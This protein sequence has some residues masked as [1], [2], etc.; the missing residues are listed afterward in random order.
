MQGN[1][2]RMSMYIHQ[3]N[4]VFP[5]LY[6]VYFCHSILQSALTQRIKVD[7]CH[8]SYSKLVDARTRPRSGFILFQEALW[9]DAVAVFISA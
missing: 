3:S 4:V 5:D 2:L 7:A 8:A 9:A 6:P 1:L